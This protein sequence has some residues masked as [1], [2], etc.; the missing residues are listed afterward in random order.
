MNWIK[1]L[2]GG[3]AIFVALCITLAWTGYKLDEKPFID[4]LAAVMVSALKVL[5]LIA[6]FVAGFYM[7]FTARA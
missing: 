1:M 6:M 2:I 4:E 5:A 3:G 7:I